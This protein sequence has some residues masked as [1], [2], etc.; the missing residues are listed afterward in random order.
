MFGMNL[1]V[2]TLY[3]PAV[4]QY[5]KIALTLYIMGVWRGLLQYEL[6]AVRT[7]VDKKL[8]LEIRTHNF[9]GFNLTFGETSGQFI[10]TLSAEPYDHLHNLGCNII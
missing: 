5:N 6:E 1:R 8:Q 9:L 4:M 7:F 10:M 3:L 2:T